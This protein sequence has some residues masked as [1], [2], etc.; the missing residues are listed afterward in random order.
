M[1]HIDHGKSTFLD[2]VRKTNVVANEAGGITQHVGAYQVE[3]VSAEGKKHAVTFLD[4]PGHEAFCGIRERGARA[5]DVAILVVSAEDGAKPQTIEA[6]KAI[7]KEKIPYIV[8]INKIDKPNA[9]INRAKKS[10]GENEIYLEGW[11]G[12]IPC[13]A[14]SALNGAGVPELLEMVILVSELAGLTFDP[15]K[16]AE[17]FVIESERDS[18]R[19]VSATLL[20]KDGTLK[21]GTFVVAGN[22][23]APVRY[24]ENFKGE[25][26]HFATASMPVR[27]VGWNEIPACGIPFATVATK[28]AAERII[29]LNTASTKSSAAMPTGRQAPVEA[30]TSVNLA[31]PT[32]TL[33][34]AEEGAAL[35]RA[36]EANMSAGAPDNLSNNEAVEE[37]NIVTLPLII[38][39][40]M[41]GS[42]EGVKHELAKIKHDKVEIKVVAEGI[43]DINENDVKTAMSDPE[44]IIVGFN[45]NPDKKAAAMIE[46]RPINMKNFSV[47]YELSE[48]VRSALLAK[49]PR[50]FIEEVTGR[51][52]ILAIFSKEKDR[53]V[54]GGKVETGIL[55]SG[56]EVKI[57]RR[58]AEIGRGKI[59]ELQEK[60]VRTNEVAEGHE[61]GVMV[62]A[63]TEIAVGDR[64]E[65]VKMI[66]K[67]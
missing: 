28:K 38:K 61:F 60:K 5:A 16:P 6:L 42:L 3:H 41:V 64:I 26:I 21:T 17:G 52:K 20:I 30:A 53:Q 19:G 40:D 24:I 44:I 35:L 59:R 7:K 31:K 8:A 32:K 33:R 47:I 63:K 45:A 22:A 27:I 11:G 50:E 55:S 13:V 12:D 1:G 14:I 37:P 15:A 34:R 46:R 39:A 48:F 23:F 25:K 56:N 62:E 58:D 29:E 51:A 66:E 18:R 67:T 43:G 57:T 2:Y 36:R 4:T 9:D 54:I 49:V 65:A 10:L